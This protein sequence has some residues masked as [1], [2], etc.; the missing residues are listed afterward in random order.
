MIPP[1][2]DPCSAQN[3]PTDAQTDA[4]CVK[5]PE[6]R[7]VEHGGKHSRMNLEDDPNGGFRCT[8]QNRCH[9]LPDDIVR[10]PTHRYGNQP[11]ME[12]ALGMVPHKHIHSS[13]CANLHA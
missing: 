9:D 11:D 3:V 5:M 6:E 7:C 8:R 12:N 4:T 10:F 1:L 2:L 13:P